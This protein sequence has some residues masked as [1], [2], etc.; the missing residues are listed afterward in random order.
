M[1]RHIY[2]SCEFCPEPILLG[3]SYYA[4]STREETMAPSV[5]WY[6]YSVHES[7][8]DMFRAVLWLRRERVDVVRLH[9]TSSG[10]DPE[11]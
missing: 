10:L 1:S 11:P 7:C 2:S 9:V 8:I 6:R 4:V 3:T 5:I